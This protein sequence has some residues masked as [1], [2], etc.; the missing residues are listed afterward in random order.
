MDMMILLAF[1]LFA[2]LVITWFLLPSA[3]VAETQQV[4]DPLPVATSQQ[5]MA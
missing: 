5:P 2:G 4:T 1:I 3:I